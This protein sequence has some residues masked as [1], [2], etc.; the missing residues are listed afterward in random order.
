MSSFVIPVCQNISANTVVVSERIDGCGSYT[1]VPFSLSPTDPN[2]GSAPTGFNWLKVET[3]N[4]FDKG[5]TVEY[6]L[7]IIGNYP[8]GIQGIR[9]RAANNTLTFSCAGCFVVPQCPL[10]GQLIVNVSC[11]EIFMN[12]NVMLSYQV[13]V[14]NAGGSPVDNVLFTDTLLF[15]NNLTLGAIAISDPTLEINRTVPGRI[16]ITG[17]L[18]TIDPGGGRV[19]TFSVPVVSVSG[20]GE[21]LIDNTASVVSSVTQATDFCTLN[22]DAVQLRADKCCNVNGSQIVYRLTLANTPNSPDTTARIVDQLTIPLGLTVQFNSFGGCNGTFRSGGE[23]PLNENITGP[24]VIDI[25]CNNLNILQGGTAVRDIQLTIVSSTTQN[26]TINNIL[27]EVNVITDFQLDLGTLNVPVTVDT[28][29]VVTISCSNPCTPPVN[30]V[31]TQMITS[32]ANSYAQTFSDDCNCGNSILN[33][34]DKW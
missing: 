7:E 21:Y 28:N 2:Y 22:L 15:S 3:S 10:P 19:I 16:L 20:A 31:S 14:S 26:A 29:Y 34:S 12:N 6:R 9:V 8:N 11:E 25:V 1:S 30:S 13:D 5:V 23:V 27:R 17:N 32:S 24:R 33:D 4:R 18:G